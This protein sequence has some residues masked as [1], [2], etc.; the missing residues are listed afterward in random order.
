MSRRYD[1]RTTTFSP[2]GR[3]FQVCHVHAEIRHVEVAVSGPLI[4]RSV[5][6]SDVSSGLF[7]YPVFLRYRV[8][9]RRSDF[10]DMILV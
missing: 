2:E 7:A 8:G 1:S 5:M 9:F 10:A 4:V 3:L 6:S